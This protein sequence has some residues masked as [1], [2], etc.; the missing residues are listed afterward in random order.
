MPQRPNPKHRKKNTELLSESDLGRN[1]RIFEDDDITQLLRA[2]IEREGSITAFA[3]RHSLPRPNVSKY[4]NGIRPISST[5]VKA[6]GLRKVHRA[7]VRCTSKINDAPLPSAV[8][9]REAVEAW[10]LN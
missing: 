2:A 7:F 9:P 10:E 5:L 3:A 4:L 6:L 8:V 1:A